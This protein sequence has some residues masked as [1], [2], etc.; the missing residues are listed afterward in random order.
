MI[1]NPSLTCS[2][3]R[4]RNSAKVFLKENHDIHAKQRALFF[5]RLTSR[6]WSRRGRDARGTEIPSSTTLAARKTARGPEDT[7]NG[8]HDAPWACRAGDLGQVDP[9]K[10]RRS[11]PPIST[12]RS[13][14]VRVD[15]RGAQ[16]ITA[17][18]A[19]SLGRMISRLRPVSLRTSRMNRASIRRT[20][21]RPRSPLRRIRFTLWRRI[22]CMQMRIG[23]RWSV[24]SKPGW[25]P[26]RHVPSPEPS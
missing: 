9:D 24:P 4:A 15:T 17:R 5:V 6:N 13:C 16:E 10:L 11:P 8:P 25:T 26:S 20:A 7:R 1:W 3:H 18:R 19:S 2:D 12:T 21:G 23:R 22:F 14:S